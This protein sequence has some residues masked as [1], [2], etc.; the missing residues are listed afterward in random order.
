MVTFF[1]GF[2]D[3]G[4][5]GGE[6][7]GDPAELIAHELRKGLWVERLPGER[8]LCRQLSISRPTLRAAAGNAR[9]SVERTS[10]RRKR[11]ENP[12]RPAWRVLIGCAE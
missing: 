6:E 3:D 5:F 2:Q 9:W 4:G 12:P 8:E 11:G 10:R 7:A 1:Q